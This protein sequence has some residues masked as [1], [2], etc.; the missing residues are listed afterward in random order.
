MG[1][2]DYVKCEYPMPKG[3]EFLIEGTPETQ[4]FQ[5]KDFENVMDKYTITREG[6]LIHH[7]YVWDMVAKKDRP[8]YG[9]PEWEENPVFRIM[10]SIKMVHI[11]DEDT[12][13][14]GH[15]RF[16]TSVKEEETY[17]DADGEER[18]KYSFYDLKAKFTDGWLVDL[19]VEGQDD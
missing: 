12:N 15:V 9:K 18:Y 16:Y 10:G 17:L 19:I 14:H 7:K 5:T 8:Y 3:Y 4:E 1:M 11:G 2:F 13:F 6:R